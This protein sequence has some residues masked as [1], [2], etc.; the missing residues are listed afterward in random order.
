MRKV[1]KQVAEAFLQ[2]R[3]R[4]VGNSASSGD[5]MLLHGNTVARRNPNGTIVATLAG[6]PTVT[7][8]ERLNGLS[9]LLGLGRPFSQRKGQQY[10]NDQPIEA[11]EWIDLKMTLSPS[12]PLQTA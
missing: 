12:P 7:T 9:E 8:R 6:W 11:D 5:E 2:R 3:N 4:Q 1:T 10:F